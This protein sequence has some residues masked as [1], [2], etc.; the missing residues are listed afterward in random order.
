MERKRPTSIE[1]LKEQQAARLQLLLDQYRTERVVVLGGTCTGKSTL[2]ENLSGARD[3]DT[4]L[5]P[6]LS[7]E[8]IEY[9]CQTPWTPEIGMT[10]T[11]LTREKVKVN[12]GEP[13][14]GTVVLD[15]DRLIYLKISDEL[16]QER[17]AQRNVSFTDA[18]NMQQHIEAE[19]MTSGLPVIT[20]DVG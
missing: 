14:F 3:M 15:A 18:K 10:M 6:L 2:V 20:F 5:F 8:E 16:L 17:T 7:S 11:R 12:P 4:L 19:M 9:V 13:V 1:A